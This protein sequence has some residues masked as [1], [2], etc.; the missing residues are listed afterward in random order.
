VVVARPI[1]SALV[2]GADGSEYNSPPLF[3]MGRGVSAVGGLASPS[4]GDLDDDLV[5]DVM[6][7]TV[8]VPHPPANGPGERW[9][10]EKNLVALDGRLLRSPPASVVRLLPGF[11][12]AFEGYAFLLAPIVADI[13]GDGHSEVIMGSSG[14]LVHAFNAQ[15]EEAREFPKFTGQWIVAS[16]AVG[17]M[18]LDDKLELAVPT[19]DGWLYAWRTH[20][21]STGRI[22]W[23]SAH[24]DARNTG[25][26]ETKRDQGRAKVGSCACAVGDRASGPGAG[27]AL[28]LVWLGARL[29]TR[30]R[31]PK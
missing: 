29:A 3:Y 26:Y 15:G 28:A 24:H 1:A 18:D 27:A 14:Y 9:D 11:P 8:A 10:F 12:R 4:I 30:R 6:L 2:L 19:R 5:P 22:D 17:N 16:A 25:N 23:P 31:R 20:G 7:P 21:I 13:D